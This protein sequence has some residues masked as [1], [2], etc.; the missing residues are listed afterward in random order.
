MTTTR[1]KERARPNPQRRRQSPRVRPRRR[2]ICQTYGYM[3][4]DKRQKRPKRSDVDASEIGEIR[5]HYK[6]GPD[7]EDRLRRLT[8]LLVKY[9]REHSQARSSDDSHADGRAGE[10]A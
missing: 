1:T 9:A 3:K 2:P 7:S 4:N 5:V 10:D 6:P 8:I